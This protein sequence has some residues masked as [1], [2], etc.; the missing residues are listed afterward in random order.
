MKQRGS[1][2]IVALLAIAAFVGPNAPPSSAQGQ[3]D[4]S[5]P[6]LLARLAADPTTPKE[7]NAQIKLHVRMRVFPWIS[8]TLNGNSAY[9]RPGIYRFV[10][11]GVPKAAEHFSDL[12]YDLG[13]ASTWPSKYEISLLT[14]ASP[15]VEPVI[16]LIPKKHGMV[17]FLDVSVDAVKG[18]I[19]KALWTRFDGGVIA[20]INHYNT[21][22]THEIVALQ[23]AT[24]DIPH[25]K[26]ELAAEYSN[27][28]VDANPVAAGNVGH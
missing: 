3:P 25:M 9:K 13:T 7:Y 15:G 2:L 6:S 26:A 28:A 21:V 18:H 14:P 22:G 19:D 11:R 4:S 16:R 24:I 23:N 17:K 1:R 10:F 20:L 27:F 5:L 12:A 8:I